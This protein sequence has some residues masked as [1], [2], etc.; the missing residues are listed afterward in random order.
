[1]RA[2]PALPR[3]SSTTTTA[4]AMSSRAYWIS[5]PASVGRPPG[6]VDAILIAAKL[7]LTVE[8]AAEIEGNTQ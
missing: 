3:T 7:E 5:G 1:M 4:F 6:Q 2:N 8:N